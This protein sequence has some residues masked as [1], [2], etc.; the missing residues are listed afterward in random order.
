MA[1]MSKVVLATSMLAKAT[2]RPRGCSAA[3]QKADRHTNS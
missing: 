1:S 2:E 3:P